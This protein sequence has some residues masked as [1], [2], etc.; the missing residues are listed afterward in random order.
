MAGN[1]ELARAEAIRQVEAGA[2]M[3]LVSVGAFGIDEK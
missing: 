3:I 1:T 2:D